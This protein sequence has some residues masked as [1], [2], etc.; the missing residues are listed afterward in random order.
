[1]A[2]DNQRRSTGSSAPSPPGMVTLT[3]RVP[4]E[5]RDALDEFVRGG[6]AE[7]RSEAARMVIDEWCQKWHLSRRQG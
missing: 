6:G 5:M 1:M 4:R 3:V 7:S 2:N